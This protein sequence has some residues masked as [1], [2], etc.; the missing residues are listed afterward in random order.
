MIVDKYHSQ[1]V[2][3]GFRLPK[4]KGHVQ[5]KLH[6]CRTGKNE[7]IE[8][9]NI[10]SNA[11]RDIM[12]ANYLGG[13]DYGNMLPLFSEWFGGILC[14]ANPHP[15]TEGVIDPDNYFP[16][17]DGHNKL[18]AHAGDI[19][20]SDIADD[21]RRGAPNTASYHYEN[22]VFT[23]G[24]E[25]GS[26]QGNCPSGTAIRALSLTHK[27]TGNCGLGSVSS[28]FANFNPYLYIQ[29]SQLANVNTVN[30]EDDVI[31]Q[32][33][34]SHGIAFYIGGEGRYGQGT[35]SERIRF[36]S[37]QITVNIRPLPYKKAGLYEK[38]NAVKT[39]GS[40]QIQSVFTVTIPFNCYCLPAYHFDYTNKYLWIFNNI[41]S[42][43]MAYKQTVDYC[44]IDCVNKTIVTQ[45]T[46][47]S[48]GTI[49]IAP[50][51]RERTG[52]TYSQ[53]TQPN[54]IK[55][56]NYVYI[57]TTSDANYGNDS[58]VNG[59]RKI[60]L[61]NAAD[62]EQITFNTAQQNL[63]SS[64]LG[65][66]LIICGGRVINNGVGYTCQDTMYTGAGKPYSFAINQPYSPSSYVTPIRPLVDASYPRFIVANKMVNTTLFNLPTPAE[67][68]SVKSMTIT[69][70]LT[71]V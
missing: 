1:E 18:I 15:N 36:E 5:I 68:T 58:Y 10:V 31:A 66:D 53:I 14:Y 61:T 29:G 50:V 69:Y 44:V 9:E 32:Y 43:E 21:L 7:I 62:Q 47:T 8:G 65:G 30:M 48:T 2:L 42:T 71:E 26:Q 25:W 49:P 3:G 23:V 35:G 17:D 34:D 67:K 55:N 38:M 37:N 11:L 16:S 59:F 52:V 45:G 56:G 27:D 57:P 70:T 28:A 64:M 19:S 41:T 12:A 20:P 60:N 63:R 54:I 40:T 24:F 13:I 22:G 4:L 33:D 39:V 46:I 6:N 51:S